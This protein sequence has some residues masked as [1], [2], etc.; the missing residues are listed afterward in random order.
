M[1]LTTHPQLVPRSRKCGSIHPLPHTPSWRSAELVKHRDNFTFTCIPRSGYLFRKYSR[2]LFGFILCLKWSVKKIK[3]LRSV[4]LIEEFYSFVHQW[5]Y[6]PLLGAGIFFSFVI[7]L[8]TDGRNP[9]TSDQPVARP[10]ATH[11]TKRT[12]NKCRYRHPCLEWDSNPRSQRS[13]ERRQFI[14]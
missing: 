13:S 2:F 4:N 8:Y 11:R 5:L 14:P 3:K 9:W 10:L 12:Q 6:S 1:K 7:F